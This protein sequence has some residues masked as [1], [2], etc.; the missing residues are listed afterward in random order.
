MLT[1]MFC[2]AYI[3]DFGQIIKGAYCIFHFEVVL[4]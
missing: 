3:K 2:H 4:P 1:G